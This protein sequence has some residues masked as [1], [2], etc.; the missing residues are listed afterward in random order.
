M[1]T[2][3]LSVFT[4]VGRV[5][6]RYGAEVPRTFLPAYRPLVMMA[7]RPTLRTVAYQLEANDSLYLAH[8]HF[9]PARSRRRMQWR[10]RFLNALCACLALSGGPEI[11][12]SEV[13][14]SIVYFL[15][16]SVCDNTIDL[17]SLASI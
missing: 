14:A 3:R 15:A 13:L 4:G 1:T 17:Q 5:L 10:T 2:F 9:M 8:S 7:T 16:A 12:P 6:S 11:F